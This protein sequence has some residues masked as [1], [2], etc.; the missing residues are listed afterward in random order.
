[1]YLNSK[2]QL[3]VDKIDYFFLAVI[4]GFYGTEYVIKKYFPLYA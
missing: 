1:M 3:V 4:I 2:H